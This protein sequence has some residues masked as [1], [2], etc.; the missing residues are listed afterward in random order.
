MVEDL[1][2]LAESWRIS[3]IASNMSKATVAAYQRAVKLYLAWCADHQIPDPTDH[4]A[5]QGFIAHCLDTGTAPTT[6]ALRHYSIKAFMIWLRDEGEIDHDPFATLKPPRLDEKVVPS[7]SDDEISL[8]LSTCR[9]AKFTDRRDEAMLKFMFETGVRANE[10][11]KMTLADVNLVAMTAVVVKGKGGKGRI[12]PFSASTA[13]AIDRY[14]RARKKVAKP[15]C[16]ALW[17]SYTRGQGLGYQAMYVSLKARARQVGLDD[18]HPHRTRHT[19]A[20][21]WLSHGG[22][23]A[24]LMAVAGWSSRAMLDRYTRASATE[25]AIEESKRLNLGI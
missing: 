17:I 20:T 11:C 13:T 18:F 6:A 16:E 21:R 2:D 23:E 7:L 8:L 5:I 10:L 3:L 15:G 14:L 1:L 9:G 4:R 19:A 22:S 12:V 24:G 25:R